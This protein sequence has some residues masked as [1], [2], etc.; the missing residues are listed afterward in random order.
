VAVALVYNLVRRRFGR[1]PG[2]VAGLALATTPIAVAISRHNNPD[3]LLVLCSVAALWLVVRGLEDGRARWLLLAGVC[4]GLGFETKMA[5]AF[6]VVPGIAAAWLWVAPRGRVRAVGQLLAGGAAMVAVGL[7]WPLLIALTPAADRPWVSGTSDNS[8]W[9]LM[10]DYN[11]LGRIAG[12]AGGP[13]ALGGGAGGGG[14]GPRG[15][16]AGGVFGGDTGPLRL[17][18]ASLGGQ[19]G[20]LL[21]FAVV[22]G[23]ALV[24][25]TRL[26]RADARSGWLIAV[27]GS[28][29]TTALAFSFAQGIFHPYYVS[30][31]APFTAALVG[32]GVPALAEGGLVMRVLAPLAV[33]GGVATELVVLHDNPSSL[34]RLPGVL[35]AAV[36]VVALGLA[37][38]G[39]K[40]LRATLLAGALALLLIAPGVWSFQTLGH[41]TSS[42]FPAGGPA[43]A[44]F[45][46]GP[47]GGGQPGGFAGG[48]GAGAGAPGGGPFGG[49]SLTGVVSYVHAHRGGTIGVASQMSASSPIIQS[50]AKVA[51]L[52]GF[53][54][55]ES[56][57]S[58]SWFAEAVRAGKV[59]W[60]VTDD[61]GVAGP[62]RD[63]R[64]GASKLM[65]AV[66]ATCAKTSRSGLY[67][68]QGR[69]DALSAYAARAAS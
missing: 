56:E 30:L 16:G 32:A 10:L 18:D 55:R 31:L 43:T 35:S 17:L 2:F 54:G 48:P 53:S 57:V 1:L 50:G 9:S 64:V 68:C 38:A 4:V 6:M 19:A 39:E 67:D 58:V 28:F 52:G 66:K 63:S 36:A 27:G 14:F 40:R 47:G 25:T 21:G 24:A 33:V 51:A 34:V 29:A 3:A 26:R 61:A 49:Q 22:A 44:G 5:A 59:R 62:M 15:A 20:W 65:T 8:I 46:G 11:G 12:Q 37:V 7:A 41:A 45:A 42:T 13:Q 23:V 60:V 69:A